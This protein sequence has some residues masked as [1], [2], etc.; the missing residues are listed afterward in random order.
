MC[1][2]LSIISPPMLLFKAGSSS[3]CLD[4]VI[5]S[6][7]SSSREAPL[8]GLCFSLAGILQ[9]SLFGLFVLSFGRELWQVLLPSAH[10][11]LS[12]NFPQRP[13]WCGQGPGSQCQP[14]PHASHGPA[15]PEVISSCYLRGI[16]HFL[17]PEGKNRVRGR[18]SH[19]VIKCVM[20]PT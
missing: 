16:L 19:P 5:A 12:A 4:T 10:C 1:R 15:G 18:F 6:I 7:E 3:L 9:N 2:R 14:S 8:T 11:R 13:Q 20:W 17:T